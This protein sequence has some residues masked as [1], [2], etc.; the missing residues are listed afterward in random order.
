MRLR[1]DKKGL[2]KMLRVKWLECEASPEE[3]DSTGELQRA[4]VASS[5][6]SF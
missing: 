5:S 6:E 3:Y 1:Q 2:Q 4:C